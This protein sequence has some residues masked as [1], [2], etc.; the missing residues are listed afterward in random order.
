MK[1]PL[2]IHKINNHFMIPGRNPLDNLSTM[3]L[4]IPVYKSRVGWAHLTAQIY[5]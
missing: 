1:Y 5:R 4:C 2:T 3:Q